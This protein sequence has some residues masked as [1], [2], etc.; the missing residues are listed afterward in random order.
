M[1]ASELEEISN[2]AMDKK[3]E[4]NVLES[5]WESFSQVRKLE[6]SLN[7]KD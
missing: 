3:E 1:P 2:L 6:N 5:L 4:S 7:I